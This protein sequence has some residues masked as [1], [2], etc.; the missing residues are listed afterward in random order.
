MFVTD[1]SGSMAGEESK[2]TLSAIAS[3]FGIIEPK[4]GMGIIKFSSTAERVLPLTKK[5]SIAFPDCISTHLTSDGKRFECGGG[6]KLWDSVLLGMNALMKRTQGGSHPKPSHPHLVVITDGEDNQSTEYN[7]DTIKEILQRPGDYAKKHDMDG[8][9]FANFHAS[10]ISVGSKQSTQSKAFAEIVKDKPNLHHF[11]A[12]GAS[13]IASCFNEVKRKIMMLKET[14]VE[15]E[16]KTKTV[17]TFK[18]ISGVSPSSNT[19]AA[20]ASKKLGPKKIGG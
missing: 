20:P 2:Q 19:V 4:D 12:D 8:K 5:R 15:V 3:I 13:E 10:L 6:T 9:T 16:V 14:H 11:H 17:E 18:K 1:V 7:K